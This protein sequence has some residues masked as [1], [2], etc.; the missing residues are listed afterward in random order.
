MI[1]YTQICGSS[2]KCYYITDDYNNGKFVTVTGRHVK[3]SKVN[4]V[5]IDRAKAH[6]EERNEI[7]WA[8]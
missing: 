5:V 1:F 8:I 7:V 2:F 6:T 3:Q 4:E